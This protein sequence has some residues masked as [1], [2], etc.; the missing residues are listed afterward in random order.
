MA[1]E[2]A[3][4]KPES[5]GPE[6]WTLSWNEAVSQIPKEEIKIPK[7]LKPWEMNWNSEYD[8]GRYA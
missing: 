7:N 4:K 2:E 8:R 6:P 5:E 3:G 1:T